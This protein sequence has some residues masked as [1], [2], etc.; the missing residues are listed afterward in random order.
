MQAIAQQEVTCGFA[1]RQIRESTAKKLSAQIDSVILLPLNESTYAKYE[2]VYWAMKLMLYHPNNYEKFIPQQVMQ[3]PSTGGDFQQ[4]FLE[5]LYTVYPKQFINQ[6]KSVWEKLAGNKVKAIA[7]EYLAVKNVFP[8]ISKTDLFYNSAYYK[9][10]KER[11]KQKK[12]SLPSKHNFLE[13]SFLPGQTLL[14][15]FQSANRNRPG[16]LML[17]NESGKWITDNQGKPLQFP[18]LA[19]SISN[20]P[21]YIT[22][23]NTPQGLYKITGLDTSDN[24][25]IGPTTNLQMILPFENGTTDF[26]GSDTAVMVAYKKFLGP[27]A[28]FRSLME[29]FEAGRLG[30]SEIIAHGTTIDPVFYRSQPYYPNTP[31]LGCLCSPELWNEKGERIYSAQ[32]NWINAMKKLALQPV[33]L[34]VA[35]VKDL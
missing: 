27:L 10:Y 20:L 14:C 32:M 19:R 15:S 5:M 16:Y 29:S 13:P 17:R 6:V 35:E 7:L 33:Y 23:G 26:F 8:E 34:I 3:L 4:A 21:Y 25:W 18:Q 30:R 12:M 31:S 22:N 9:I 11:W 2:G 28:K 24:N 1:T